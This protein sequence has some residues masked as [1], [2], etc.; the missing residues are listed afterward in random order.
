MSLLAHKPTGDRGRKAYAD[1]VAKQTHPDYWIMITQ[2]YLWRSSGRTDERECRREKNGFGREFLLPNQVTDST[3]RNIQ[4][5]RPSNMMLNPLTDVGVRMF[6]AVRIGSGQ[7]MVNIL[8]DGKRSQPQNDTD[9]PQ[10]H[11]ESE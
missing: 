5:N 7:F 2:L 3:S 10:G 6:M 1:R 11:P 9:H 8:S 4:I